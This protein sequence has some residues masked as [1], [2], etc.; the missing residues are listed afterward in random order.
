VTT[1]MI[2]AN[3]EWNVFIRGMLFPGI[4]F[5]ILC[6][7]TYVILATNMGNR[8]G[9]LVAV[10]GLVGWMFLMSIVWMLYGIGLRGS[11]PKW[12]VTDVVTGTDNLGIVKNENVAPIGQTKFDSGWC[13]TEKDVL[14]SAD[15]KKAEKW[16]EKTND[17]VTDETLRKEGKTVVDAIT[18]QRALRAAEAKVEATFKA[19]RDKVKKETGWEPLCVGSGQRGDGQATV[20]ATLVVKKKDPTLTPQAIFKEPTEY[21]AISAYRQGGDNALFTL[22]THGFHL[23]HSPH[24]F[25][26][27]VQPYKTREIEEPVLG[28]GRVQLVN[29]DGTPQVTKKTEYLK[30]IDTTK[31]ITTVVML[32]DQGSRRQ[33][34]FILFLSSGVA[35]AI[36]ASVLH[37]RD[38]QLMSLTGKLKGKP[39]SA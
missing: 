36:L 17:K 20:D 28:A 13:R 33:P 8:L 25:V 32:R 5:L 37:Q 38:K 31:P 19:K 9:F 39:A 23:R 10:T 34:P 11:D 21:A 2:L 24:W 27:Q 6:G 30:E 18:K 22:R 1:A 4:M 7:S 29:A 26:M 14:N 35:F 12:K 3:F 15:Y 16:I